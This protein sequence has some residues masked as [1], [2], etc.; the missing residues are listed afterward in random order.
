MLWS[1][2]E[3]VFHLYSTINERALSLTNILNKSLKS[4]ELLKKRVESGTTRKGP[5]VSEVE[6]EIDSGSD[7]DEQSPKKSSECEELVDSEYSLSDDENFV[8]M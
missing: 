7:D 2:L 8:D 3:I 6:I 1:C 5:K 4:L